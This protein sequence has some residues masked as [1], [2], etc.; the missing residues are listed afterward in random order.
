MNPVTKRG[1]RRRLERINQAAV[2]LWLG[3]V[4]EDGRKLGDVAEDFQL[5]L[6]MWALD[7]DSEPNRIE[8]RPRGGAK[9]SDTAALMVTMLLK[10]VAPGSRAYAFAADRDQSRLIIDAIRGYV[11]RTPA[12]ANTLTV[13]NYTVTARNGTELQVMASDSA[14][15]WGLKPA[16]VFVDEW[17][18]LPSTTNTETLWQAITSSMGKVPGAKLLCASTAG[19]PG[20]WQHRVWETARNSRNWSTAQIEGPLPWVSK[21]FLAEQRAILPDSAYQR[22]HLDRWA[23]PEDRLAAA[24]DVRACVAFS[25]EKGQWPLPKQAGVGRYVM[26]VDLALVRDRAV[27]ALM[28][29]ERAENEDGQRIVARLVLDR[30]QVWKPSHKD[31]LDFMAVEEWIAYTAA[32]YGCVVYVDPYQAMSTVQRIRNRGVAIEPVNFTMASNDRMAVGLHTL[33]RSH[34]LAIPDD[35]ELI[36]ELMTIRLVEKNGQFKLEHDA[37]RHNDRGTALSLAILQLTQIQPQGGRPII[38][39]DA[40]LNAMK[41]LEAQAF[42]TLPKP[43]PAIPGRAFGGSTGLPDSTSGKF[44]LEDQQASNGATKRSPFA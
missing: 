28:H 39:S 37:S 2:T 15:A 42:G 4:L 35:E 20:S 8:L 38:Y 32:E 21:E 41:F 11:S 5:R 33:I 44:E 16:I 43:V 26:G 6:L 34:R 18:Q 14:S 9:T 40:E 29:A 23:S 1:I 10:V 24:D 22:L 7:P 36:E 30:L 3:L 27:C 17:C 13:N 31:P 19:D 12:L 25:I